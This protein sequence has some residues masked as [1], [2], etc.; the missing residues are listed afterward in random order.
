M[1]PPAGHPASVPHPHRPSPGTTAARA[2]RRWQLGWNAWPRPLRRLLGWLPVVVAL[3][4]LGLSGTEPLDLTRARSATIDPLLRQVCRHLPAPV[5]ITVLSPA[6][7]QTPDERVFAAAVGPFLDVVERCRAGGAPLSLRM[8]DGSTDFTLAPLLEQHPEIPRPGVLLQLQ[9]DGGPPRWQALSLADLAQLGRQ[10]DGQIALQSF[11]QSAL[12]SALDRLARP[13][14]ARRLGWV[15]GHGEQPRPAAL[16][17]PTPLHPAD[18]TLASRLHLAGWSVEAVEL[19]AAPT[20]GSRPAVWVI[21]GGDQPWTAT[22]VEQ[23]QHHLQTGGRALI[24]VESLGGKGRATLA[25]AFASDPWRSLWNDLGVVL[26]HDQLVAWGAGNRVTANI[27]LQPPTGQPPLLR[28]VPGE[29]LTITAPRSVR[30]RVGVEQSSL[31]VQPLLLS[32]AAPV[33]WAET[34]RTRPP[35]YHPGED[36]PGP[37]A[38]AVAVQRLSQGAAEPVAVVVGATDFLL[39]G[40]SASGSA[41]SALTWVQASLDWLAEGG[42]SRAIPPRVIT[43]VARPTSATGPPRV[44]WTFGIVWS[45]LCLSL[46]LVRCWS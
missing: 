45:A 12:H 2:G 29:P 42:V 26:G 37:V 11:A 15:T 27:G 10:P 21:A 31:A 1:F 34:D 19:H 4:A 22:E 20:E 32:P 14:A 17:S 23:L 30:V 16:T 7:P 35:E 28:W 6:V 18:D 44:L 8:A 43:P 25:P 13:G 41:N 3:L 38:V 39:P 36:L 40:D 9:P 46:A 5:Q 24:L 33:S